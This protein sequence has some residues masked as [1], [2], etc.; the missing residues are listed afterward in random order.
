ML[1]HFNVNFNVSF[2]NFLEQSSCVVSWINKRLVFV[3]YVL[4]LATTEHQD[5]QSLPVFKTIVRLVFA[6]RTVT[7]IAR[8]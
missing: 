5:Q 3:S 2:K 8:H 1:E 7:V 4:A 6:I